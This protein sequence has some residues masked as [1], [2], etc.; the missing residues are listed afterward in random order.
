[1]VLQSGWWGFANLLKRAYGAGRTKDNEAIM[2][3]LC[4]F[5]NV[6]QLLKPELIINQ[7]LKLSKYNYNL[8]QIEKEQRAACNSRL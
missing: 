2:R 5:L 8:W 7:E 1:M 6:R 3:F 4:I